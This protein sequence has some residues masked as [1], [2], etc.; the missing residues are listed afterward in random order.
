MAAAT[1]L[2]EHVRA[3]GT[4]LSNLE[5][6]S[7]TK[8]SQA[9]RDSLCFMIEGTGDLP[10]TSLAP[11][12][13]AVRNAS[14]A[15]EDQ[16]VLLEKLSTK[17]AS[18][19]EGGSK[20]QS[21]ETFVFFLPAIVWAALGE[22]RECGA[23]K[24]FDFLARLGLRHPTEPTSF[25]MALLIM[26]GAD[27][28][29]KTSG[30]SVEMKAAMH[31]T[32][33]K[34]FKKIVAH[35][36]NPTVWMKN[37]PQRPADLRIQQPDLYNGLYA[38]AP[39]VSCP[40]D[41]LLLEHLKSSSR[42]RMPRKNPFETALAPVSGTPRG[43][44]VVTWDGLYML[45]Q[46][47]QQQAP[48]PSNPNGDVTLKFPSR[49]SGGF[50]LM[51]PS[52]KMPPSTG[53]SPPGFQTPAP[54]QAHAE[55]SPLA[56]P[57]TSEPV[58]RAE[59]EPANV[60][61]AVKPELSPPLNDNPRKK[62]RKSVAEATSIIISA[63]DSKKR[64][65]A[66]PRAMKASKAMK[67]MKT[68]ATKVENESSNDD[69]SDDEEVPQAKATKVENESSDDEDSDDEDEESS[70]EDV[71]LPTFS[72]EASRK[73]F[74]GRT[75]LKGPGQSKKFV[76]TDKKSRAKAES[77]CKKWCKKLCLKSGLDV[78]PKFE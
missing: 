61:A 4:L 30:F 74:L 34:W 8:C 71:A 42:M 14:F 60:G 13:V 26:L 29:E 27:G 19:A 21:F 41:A 73:Q 3:V 49:P 18:G 57:E 47:F 31:K 66:A 77:D 58:R 37:L 78:P 67:A 35:L 7:H 17:V 55:E 33:K 28:I 48:P 15:T 40:Y 50:P 39:P 32:V 11:I 52:T 36:A 16:A 12:V 2:L 24:L 23:S 46:H 1:A 6:P 38:S 59:V 69:T 25:M 9:Q 75:G 62:V 72:H 68:K 44:G 10:A 43:P 65:K 64:R 51:P 76:Y 20:L 22:D 45:M 5:G 53:L 63:M 56:G 54:R 70:E